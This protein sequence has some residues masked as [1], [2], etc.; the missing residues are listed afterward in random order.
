M[1]KSSSSTSSVLQLLILFN[2]IFLQNAIHI[3][4]TFRTNEFFKLL[5]KF[6]FQ[7]TER[8]SQRDSY[9]YIYG[10]IT[11][12]ENFPVPITFAVLDKYSFLPYYGNRT[13]YHRDK[14]CQRMFS[15]IDQFAFDSKCSPKNKMDFL[16]RIPCKHG[17]LCSDEDNK[18]NV[19]NGNQFTYVISDLNQPR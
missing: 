5:A 4:G 8:H 9:G 10:N 18:T 3:T 7:K 19:I 6:G 1:S 14:A 2:L 16:R 15:T 17:E 12:K 11:S 13:L